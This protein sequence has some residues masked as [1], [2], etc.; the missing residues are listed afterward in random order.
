MIYVMMWF[1]ARWSQFMDVFRKPIACQP[2][3]DDEG[4]IVTAHSRDC[5][6]DES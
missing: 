2:M 3:L 4:R 6:C 1:E 5:R